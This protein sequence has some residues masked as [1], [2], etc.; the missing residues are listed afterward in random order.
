MS[1]GELDGYLTSIN[2][3]FMQ[4]SHLS[5]QSTLERIRRL[6]SGVLNV[7][8]KNDLHSGV[9][10]YFVIVVLPRLSVQGPL[11]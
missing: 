5:S 1:S 3:C 11:D 4:S 7:R 9:F 10:Y 8:N 6:P 2:D